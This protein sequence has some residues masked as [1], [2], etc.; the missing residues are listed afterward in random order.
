[1]KVRIR[2]RALLVVACW[3]HADLISALLLST[4]FVTA[5]LLAFSVLCVETVQR[6]VQQTGTEWVLGLP[7]EKQGYLAIAGTSLLV[8][9]LVDMYAAGVQNAGS[10]ADEFSAES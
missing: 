1:M 5:G 6:L 9:K 3:N 4:F 10:I 2:P 7:L 8:A